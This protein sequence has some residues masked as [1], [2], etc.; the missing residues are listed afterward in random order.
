MSNPTACVAPAMV[1]RV[2]LV[3]DAEVTP[4][5]FIENDP[6]DRVVLVAID[7]DEMAQ[8]LVFSNPSTLA[9]LSSAPD[10][11]STPSPPCSSPPQPGNPKTP[12][13]PDTPNTPNT[14]K[15]IAFRFMD[16]LL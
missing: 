9:L 12:N 3:I 1:P 8:P 16:Y 13:T 15:A 4:D 2:W 14:P 7:P 6:C 10:I 11:I 5:V